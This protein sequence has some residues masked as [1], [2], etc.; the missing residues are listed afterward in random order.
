MKMV[1]AYEKRKYQL[2]STAVTPQKITHTH[3]S[4]AI[5]M[6]GGNASALI[7]NS[8]TVNLYPSITYKR[9]SKFI[10]RT[11]FFATRSC[12]SK[13][14]WKGQEKDKTPRAL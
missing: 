11:F 13:D 8:Q 14:K 1:F 6:F 7:T 4:K 3:T 10:E 12:E 5:N 2:T 9:S